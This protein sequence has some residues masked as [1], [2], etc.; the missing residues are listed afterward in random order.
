MKRMPKVMLLAALMM[1]L[2]LAA[3]CGASAKDQ[4]Q[5]YVDASKPQVEGLN[6]TMADLQNPFESLSPK[7]D[8]TWDAAAGTLDTAA[9][10][11]GSTADGFGSITPPDTLKS[12]HE[13]L[14][15]GLNDIEKALQM[16]SAQLKDGTFG[17][18]TMNDA[19][20]NKLLN[21][22]SAKR[23][24]WKTALEKQCKDL[25]VTIPWKWQ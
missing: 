18:A 10:A 9:K 5:S 22:G 6:K 24:A 2:A 16:M 14:I 1:A 4:L 8:A 20:L 17:P 7:K 23:K 25:G 3:A 12:A 21:G 11:I 13:G 19:T 15:V